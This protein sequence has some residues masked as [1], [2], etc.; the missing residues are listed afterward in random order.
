MQDTPP[1]DNVSL[2][3][4][5]DDELVSIRHTEESISHEAA[6]ALLLLL[7]LLLM[8]LL[9]LQQHLQPPTI[10]HLSHSPT[11]GSRPSIRHPVRHIIASKKLGRACGNA[12]LFIRMMPRRKDQVQE[13][14]RTGSWAGKKMMKK[15]PMMANLPR[16]Q[17]PRKER[18]ELPTDGKAM[19]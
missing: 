14:T 1:L 8:R 17:L 16:I 12:L 19:F 18:K 11:D 5:N 3:L 7:L 13:P 10:Y 4:S 6:A 15:L 9:R 2:T